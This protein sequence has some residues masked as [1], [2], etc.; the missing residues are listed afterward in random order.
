MSSKTDTKVAWLVF[1]TY[2]CFICL[3]LLTIWFA[4]SMVGSDNVTVIH[5]HGHECLVRGS[6]LSQT[7]SCN[8]GK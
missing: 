8:W 6:A 1:L 3:M 5:T 2:L 7:M 4:G